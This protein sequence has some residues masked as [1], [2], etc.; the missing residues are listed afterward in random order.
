VPSAE[1]I[2]A[3]KIMERI[4]EYLIKRLVGEGGMGKVYEAEERLSKRRVALKVLRPE[5]TRS[6]DARRLFL[7]EMQILAHLEHPSIVRSLASMEVDG[8]LAIA[9]EYLSGQT[10]RD[11]LTARD[12]LPW[13][14]AVEIVVKICG[15]LGV[16]HAQ[17]PAIVHRDLKPENVM[18]TD[19]G[20]LKVMDFG[21]AKVLEAVHATNTQSIGTLQYMSPEQIDAQ[22]IDAR[23]DLYSLGLIF[24]EMLAG[25]PPF[26]S[27]SPR[28]LLNMQCTSPAPSLPDWVRA[29]LPRGVEDVLFQ[30]LEKS[31]GKRPSTAQEVAD[32]LSPFC[33][34][35]ERAPRTPRMANAPRWPTSTPSPAPDAARMSPNQPEP[36][37]S[38]SS[39][40]S[41]VRSGDTLCSDVPEETKD[42]PRTDTV[43]LVEK[44]T[45]PRQISTALALV[46]IVVLSLLAGITT[47]VLR[48]R[49]NAPEPASSSVTSARAPTP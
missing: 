22:T 32:R 23:S 38:S 30:M 46:A 48:L 41:R 40:S 15:A 17:Q 13:Q 2:S 19:D 6:E 31:P 11:E 3:E 26:H 27:A 7:N 12:K 42:K 33:A 4:G 20:G 49:A 16:A 28:E 8:Q 44:A 25:S 5:L 29:G 1:K 18:L 24:Y 9:L 37:A 10:L 14:E 36:A 39:S 45:E 35:I 43:A 34:A 21:I 47:Y